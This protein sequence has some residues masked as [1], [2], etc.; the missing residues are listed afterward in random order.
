RLVASETDLQPSFRREGTGRTEGALNDGGERAA[1]LRRGDAF[2]EDAAAGGVGE[3]MEGPAAVGDGATDG[4]IGAV[5][6]G[7][8]LLNGGVALGAVADGLTHG[9]PNR[10]LVA[11][12]VHELKEVG[13]DDEAV[14]EVPVEVGAVAVRGVAGA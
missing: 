7:E 2:G 3:E 5:G 9:G 6:G 8:P 11:E 14:I 10:R 12:S 4:G 1:D 13:L